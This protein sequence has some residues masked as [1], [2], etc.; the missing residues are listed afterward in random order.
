MACSPSCHPGINISRLDDPLF[1]IIMHLGF[2]C[3]DKTGSHLHAFRAQHK[4]CRNSSSVRDTSRR[5]DR[6][7]Y[8]ICDLRNQ[9]HRRA[10]A[11]M[12]SGLAALGYQCIR[13]ASLH[14]FCKSDRSND[15]NDLNSCFFPHLHILFRISRPGGDNLN[16][17]F[18]DYFCHLVR[19]R[20]HKH[21]VYSE[22]LISKLFCFPHL[23]PYP[24]RRCARRTYKPQASRIRYRCRKVMLGYPCHSA[25]NN[26]ILNPQ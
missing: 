8:C 6:N 18:H 2:L 3:H 23:F 20:A 9:H 7:T 11:D 25:L 1:V 5:D 21:N 26:R 4:C 17:F 10:L 22:R 13:A 16:A 14:T 24:V 19:I 15:R 12:S